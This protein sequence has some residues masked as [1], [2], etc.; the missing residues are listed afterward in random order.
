MSSDQ[1]LND[2]MAAPPTAAT[3]S[4]PTPRP[5]PPASPVARREQPARTGPAQAARF[6]AR[7]NRVALSAVVSVALVL[8]LAMWLFDGYATA[9][10][11]AGAGRAYGWA[12]L[13]WSTGIVSH[14]VFS[15][16]QQHGYRVVR[17]VASVPEL[18]HLA[19][20]VRWTF[21]VITVVLGAVNTLTT[22]QMLALLLPGVSGVLLVP[23]A[24]LV[25]IVAEPMIVACLVMLRSIRA[26]GGSHA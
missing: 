23:F 9:R 12:L 26:G 4:S 5:A 21:R 20:L 3:S 24:L 18:A 11:V 13:T 10:T 15:L 17:F 1:F 19:G 8:F 2:L 14:L 7:Y 25:A 6:R 22:Q 16:F